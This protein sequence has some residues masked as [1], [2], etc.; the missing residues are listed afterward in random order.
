M[1][2]EPKAGVGVLHDE[3]R[4]SGTDIRHVQNVALADATAKAGVSPWTPA[5]FR[6]SISTQKMDSMLTLCSFTLVCSW[7]H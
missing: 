6:V 4:E 7:Q 2:S 3:R 5:M 1:S